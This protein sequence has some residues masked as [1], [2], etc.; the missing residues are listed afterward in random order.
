MLAKAEAI[1]ILIY[2]LS[3]P[4]PDLCIFLEE[5]WLYKGTHNFSYRDSDFTLGGPGADAYGWTAQ[6]IVYDRD[7]ALYRYSEN[8]LALI[9]PNNDFRGWKNENIRVLPVGGN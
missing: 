1:P 6:G 7:G 3:D 2:R 4:E 9:G 5:N 8:Q